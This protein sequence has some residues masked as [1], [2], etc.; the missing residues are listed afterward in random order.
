MLVE[1]NRLSKLFPV[2]RSIIGTPKRHVHA[3][4]EVSMSIKRGRTLALVGESGSGKTTIGKIITGLLEPTN[5]EVFFKSVNLTNLKKKELRNYRKNIQFIFQDP[6]SSLNPRHNIRTIL[7]RPFEI[8]TDLSQTDITQKIRDLLTS[9]GLVPPDALM[10]R[11]PHQFSGG[12]RQRIVFAR[13]I[14]LEPEFIVCDEPVSS[15][16]MSVKAQLLTLLRRFQRELDLT[17]LFITHELSVTRTV[18]QDISVMYL[19]K[20]VESGT[21]KDFFNGPLHPYSEALLAATPILNPKEARLSKR[22]IL[23]GPLPSPTNP[24]SGCYLNTRCPY[25]RPICSKKVPVF[26]EYGERKVAC[27]FIGQA[28]FPLTVNLSPDFHLKAKEESEP[29]S[30]EQTSN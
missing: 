26:R 6:Y 25:V 19:G 14:A 3:V 5:G 17:Y 15:L 2:G 22:I 9:V 11:Y 23:R 12:Q 28:E 16:D 10:N 21:I 29:Y 20:I 4:T 18:A 24:P 1:T 8:H 13:A 7:A 27:H 30:Q